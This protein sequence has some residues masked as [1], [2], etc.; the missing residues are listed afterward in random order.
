[1]GHIRKLGATLL[2]FAGI[3]LIT[4][5][6]VAAFESRTPIEPAFGSFG[7][8]TGM[9]VDQSNGDTYVLDSSADEVFV[10]GPGG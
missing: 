10:F 5:G 2:A 4:S 3:G 7:N 8:A 1:M 6:P 9:A